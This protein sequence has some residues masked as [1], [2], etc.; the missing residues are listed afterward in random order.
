MFRLTAKITLIS[1][2]LFCTSVVCIQGSARPYDIVELRDSIV[3]EQALNF[4]DT[5]TTKFGRN[6]NGKTHQQWPAQ[7][8]NG[9]QYVTYYDQNRNVCLGR[10]K[11][12][13]GEWEIIRF[14][15]YQIL[16]NDSH[17]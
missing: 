5:E 16:S 9:Y 13:S 4:A 11:L 2:S 15:D 8:F 10:R 1:L 7:T 14:T 12:P 17:N 3:D 6:I